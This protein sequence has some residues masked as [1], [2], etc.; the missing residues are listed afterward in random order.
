MLCGI[1]VG[2]LATR[3]H[4]EAKGLLPAPD[5]G[6]PLAL[7]LARIVRELGLTPVLVGRD[8]R[9]RAALPDLLVIADQPAGVGPLGGLAGLLRAGEH[10]T[11]PSPF[12]L[13]LSCD[14][15]R[16]SSALIERLA[17]QPARA[18]V[19]APRAPEGRWEPLIA[20]YDARA[21]RGPVEHAIALGTRS[22]QRL[23]VDLTVEELTLSA[24]ERAQL[25]DWD[26][27]DDV[28]DK[29]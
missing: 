12:V 26:T 22:F 28:H 4:G 6:E 9:Y 20:R 29:R 1:F 10:D 15:P 24:S 18:S 13:A 21:L 8:A 27:P 11:A 16:I 3:M 23:F 5:T 14:L 7:R 19:L 25:I 2:G 17:S